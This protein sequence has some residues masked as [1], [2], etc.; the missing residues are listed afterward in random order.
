MKPLYPRIYERKYPSGGLYW[1][2]KCQ[3]PGGNPYQRKHS[4]ELDAVRDRARLIRESTGSAPISRSDLQDY[5]IARHRLANCE[6][7]AKGRSVLE[8]V[9]FFV[10]HY[11][12][13]KRTPLVREALELF[14]R[15]H[16]PTLRKESQ[17][18]Y[19]RYLPKLQSRFG[20]F[21]LRE[22]TTSVLQEYINSSSAKFHH[23]KCLQGFFSFCSGGSRKVRSPHEWLPKNPIDNVVLPRIE[24]DREIVVLTLDEVK[25]ALALASMVGDLPYW[26]WS[27]FT[28]MRPCETKKFWTLPGYGWERINFAAGSVVVNTEIAKDKRRR[29]IAI[30]PNLKKWLLLFLA[31][32]EPMYPTCHRLKHREVKRGALDRDKYLVK[33]IL[34][35]TFVSFRVHAFDGSIGATAAESGNSER[36]IKDHYFDLITDESTV[37]AFW[38]LTPEDF[39]FTTNSAE[40]PVEAQLPATSNDAA[41][42]EAVGMD[43]A[44]LAIA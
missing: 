37:E 21:R 5:D 17:D 11:Q 10:R 25:N 7:D 35:H 42:G 34:R 38:S 9:D 22:I 18:E 27:L 20:E 36:I 23:R 26:V 30:R 15:D 24:G 31:S 4:T 14:R 40:A 29:K 19:E 12:D 39:G 32:E 1:L 44:Y 16:L 33:D 3:L 6:G 41:A 43:P 13:P 28:G 8:A 2:V